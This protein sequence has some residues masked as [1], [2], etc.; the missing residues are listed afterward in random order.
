MSSGLEAVTKM[1][2]VLG[3][4][5]GPAARRSKANKQAVLVERKACFI[6]DAGI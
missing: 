3:G 5:G 2:Y 6:S 4:G 1:R